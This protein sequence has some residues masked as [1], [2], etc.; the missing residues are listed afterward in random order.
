M[1]FSA[2]NATYAGY[3]ANN[4]GNWAW[5][6]ARNSNFSVNNSRPYVK[7]KRGSGD[8]TEQRG[9]IQFDTSSIPSG[10]KVSSLV[11]RVTSDGYSDTGVGGSVRIVPSS[12]TWGS[13]ADLSKW[14][15][16]DIGNLT[17]LSNGSHDITM[18]TSAI[19]K[20]GY[21]SYIVLHSS[22]Y[23]NSAP[24]YGTNQEFQIYFTGIGETLPQ[25]RVTYT[26]IPTVTT[27]VASQVGATTATLA[28][29]VTSDGGGTVSER[30]V[31]WGL[32]ANPTTSSSKASTSGT[33]GAYTVSA[34]GLGAGM[35]Y[36]YR[37]YVIT[38]NSTQYG[39]DATFRTQGGAVL[40]NL[41]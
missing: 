13:L 33:T 36:H 37:A 1:S 40:F 10:A 24:G 29:N 20:A 14:T 2:I 28:G 31:C 41:L 25:L 39:A 38:E 18:A 8:Y 4:S 27:G 5:V 35:E 9:F 21:T 6:M 26:E 34:T 7:F 11:L 22:I 17:S 32:T 23:A 15:A 12:M 19:T 16:S 3:C 30:G